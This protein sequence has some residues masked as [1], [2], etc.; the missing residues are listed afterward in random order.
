MTHC[1][2][3]GVELSEQNT[4]VEHIIPNALGGRLKSKTL[5][6]KNCNSE[7]GKTLD[8]NLTGDF[9]GIATLLN[10]KLERGEVDSVEAIAADG[11]PLLISPTGKPSI[12]NPV[13]SE[14]QTQDAK[15]IH[16]SARSE[17]EMAAFIK[18]IVAKYPKV[19]GVQMAAAVQRST[20]YLKDP[21]KISFKFG[22]ADSFR[23]LLKIALE[24]RLLRV[25]SPAN[26]GTLLKLLTSSQ[27][28]LETVFFSHGFD[29]FGVDQRDV[30][31]H[32][33]SLVGSGGQ[34]FVYAHIAL[35][36]F[37]R[38]F[39]ILENEYKG[40]D[41]IQAYVQN[42]ITGQEILP[43][44]HEVATRQQI[45]DRKKATDWPPRGFYSEMNRVVGIGVAE[46][47][48]SHMKE[49]FADCL[50]RWGERH[51][52]KLITEEMVNELVSNYRS[53]LETWFCRSDHQSH[54]T[55]NPSV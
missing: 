26:I 47:E 4:S 11:T 48:I 52:G 36:G 27:D 15:H 37:F 8:A 18:S 10:I 7:F 44:R 40:S 32:S 1:F 6:C 5:L 28:V 20:E 21:A 12:K 35:F 34:G 22:G 24:F 14:N 13:F 19:D 50:Q 49:L 23:S 39:V 17:K 33:I 53:V 38:V 3:C 2:K 29:P 43:A 25:G 46:M 42:A 45:E 31:T 30:V 55:G 16:F 54:V 9:S 51:D 41:F